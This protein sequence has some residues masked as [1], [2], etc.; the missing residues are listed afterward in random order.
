MHLNICAID[1]VFVKEVNFVFEIIYCLSLNDMVR[2]TIPF[3]NYSVREKKL[4]LVLFVVFLFILYLWPLSLVL[5][6]K[7]KMG[8]VEIGS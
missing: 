2:K 3:I 6:S 4:Y 1:N 7:L 8:S 5:V